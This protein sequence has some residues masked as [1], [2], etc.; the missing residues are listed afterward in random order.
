M[1]DEF[2]E[3]WKLVIPQLSPRKWRRTPWN[4]SKRKNT[5]TDKSRDLEGHWVIRLVNSCHNL[6]IMILIEWTVTPSYWNHV[7]S[8]AL[9]LFNSGTRKVYIIWKLCSKLTDTVLPW[10]FWKIYGPISLHQATLHHTITLGLNC[11]ISWNNWGFV[12]NQYRKFCFLI[13]PLKYKFAS[14][15][16]SIFFSSIISWSCT[17]NTILICWQFGHNLWTICSL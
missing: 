13:N 2:H 17:Q 9:I 15:D 4:S 11:D 16:I 8:R 6:L 14:S 5:E 3:E 10:G 7:V 12:S 1:R